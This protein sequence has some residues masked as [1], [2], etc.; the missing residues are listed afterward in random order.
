MGEE[1]RGANGGRCAKVGRDKGV[2][3]IAIRREI[4]DGSSRRVVD[5]VMGLWEIFGE[6]AFLGDWEEIGAAT[7][8]RL[9][10]GI[11]KFERESLQGL[12]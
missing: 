12:G 4:D 9:W 5:G 3:L 1:Y 11:G 10:A 8:E 2:Q 6:C 7:V